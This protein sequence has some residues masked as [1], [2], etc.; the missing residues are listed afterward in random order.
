MTKKIG[1]Q[2]FKRI[3]VYAAARAETK[4]YTSWF[5]IEEDS[6]KVVGVPRHCATWL[7][8]IPQGQPEDWMLTKYILVVSKPPSDVF[9]PVERKLQALVDIRRVAEEVGARIIVRLHPY[10]GIEVPDIFKAGL[11]AEGFGRTWTVSASHS[12][13]LGRRALC[14]V[15]F[16]SSVAVDLA[17]IGVPVIEACDFSGL[18]DAPQLP[19]DGRGNP[20][21]SYQQLGLAF[22]ASNY[23]ELRRHVL[24]IIADRET[25]TNRLRR[26]YEQVYERVPNSVA[27]I[28]Q[29]ILAA[30]STD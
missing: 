12:I 29:D 24:N 1:S 23:E 26:A 2:P 11:G 10:E 5:G 27:V 16:F 25:V 21:S 20:T 30:V 13:A 22:G 7:G 14:A 17:A 4:T 18:V 9:L 8:N 3:T 15:T 28:A 6:V 19:R